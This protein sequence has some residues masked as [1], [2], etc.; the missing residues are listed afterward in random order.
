MKLSNP[1]ATWNDKII[2]IL[3]AASCMGENILKQVAHRIAIG[4]EHMEYKDFTEFDCTCEDQYIFQEAQHLI[5]AH[6]LPFDMALN[7][8]VNDRLKEEW[9]QTERAIASAT[10]NKLNP[11]QIDA[12]VKLSVQQESRL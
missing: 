11:A 12:L 2:A 6:R 3:Q 10:E 1:N 9:M 5:E 8:T 4:R 7:V